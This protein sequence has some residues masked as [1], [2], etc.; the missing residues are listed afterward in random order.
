MSTIAL[1]QKVPK[2]YPKGIFLKELRRLLLKELEKS[3]THTSKG[4]F[5]DLK[6]LLLKELQKFFIQESK[7]FYSS[8]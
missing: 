8:N 4:F 2:R 5:K 1:M 3:L 7:V 6:G